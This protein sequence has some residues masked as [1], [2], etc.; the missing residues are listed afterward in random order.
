MSGIDTNIDIDKV[1]LAIAD[2]YHDFL[3]RRCS[4]NGLEP[5][6]DMIKKSIQR[7]TGIEETNIPSSKMF[8]YNGINIKN[9]DFMG[10]DL[11]ETVYNMI[12]LYYGPTCNKSTIDSDILDRILLNDIDVINRFKRFLFNFYECNIEDNDKYYNIGLIYDQFGINILKQLTNQLNDGKNGPQILNIHPICGLW[13]EAGKPKTNRIDVLIGN[14]SQTNVIEHT[15]NISFSFTESKNNV[16]LFN[17][18]NNFT[19]TELCKEIL[20]LGVS[21]LCK[22]YA[23]AVGKKD[24]NIINIILNN[25]RKNASCIMNNSTLYDKI[26]NLFNIELFKNLDHLNIKRSGDYGQISLV[27][28]LNLNNNEIKPYALFKENKRPIENTIDKLNNNIRY[29]LMT[30]DRLCCS[31][32]I[33]EGVPVIFY[34]NK[35]NKLVLYKNILQP[36]SINV[37]TYSNDLHDL[38]IKLFDKLFIERETQDGT[39]TR[40]NVEVREDFEEARIKN[41]PNIVSELSFFRPFLNGIFQNIPQTNYNDNLKKIIKIGTNIDK[42]LLELNNQLFRLINQIGL[43]QLNMISDKMKSR[44]KKLTTML[45]EDYTI[46]MTERFEIIPFLIDISNCEYKGNT[47]IITS[48]SNN[49]ILSF[50]DSII[51]LLSKISLYPSLLH[52]N[53]PNKLFQ[54]IIGAFIDMSIDTQYSKYI[55]LYHDVEDRSEKDMSLLLTAMQNFMKKTNNMILRGYAKNLDGL[56]FFKPIDAYLYVFEK[57]TD[58]FISRIEQFIEAVESKIL[59]IDNINDFLRETAITPSG[60]EV[61]MTISNR[62]TSNASMRT[63]GSTCSLDSTGNRTGGAKKRQN[64]YKGGKCEDKIIM[65]LNILLCNCDNY[66]NSNIVPDEMEDIQIAMN[67]IIYC[68]H[69]PINS[70]IIQS[71]IIEL[72]NI[73][74]ITDKK[75]L[76]NK[77]KSIVFS[78]LRKYILYYHLDICGNESDQ[79]VLKD[80]FDFCLDYRKNSLCSISKLTEEFF[81]NFLYK[82]PNEQTQTGRKSLDEYYNYEHKKNYD[83]FMTNIPEEVDINYIE[84]EIVTMHKYISS[85][86]KDVYTEIQRA[87]AFDP[88]G[89]WSYMLEKFTTAP[90]AFMTSVGQYLIAPLNPPAITSGINLQG[91]CTPST[92]SP[93]KAGPSTEA[94]TTSSGQG[95]TDIRGSPMTKE[96][97]NANFSTIK[98]AVMSTGNIHQESED[99]RL[100]NELWYKIFIDTQNASFEEIKSKFLSLSQQYNYK[101]YDKIIVSNINDIRKIFFENLRI[102]L[103]PSTSSAAMT[104]GSGG[105]IS[106]MKMKLKM[107]D[108]HRKYFTGYYNKY[109]AV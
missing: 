58:I 46:S 17:N 38:I 29:V 64:K 102:N 62:T 36:H 79:Y 3:G 11:E 99:K 23:E 45:S 65:D 86:I 48:D 75:E 105:G 33:I 108:Y 9:T 26:K 88:S 24:K 51:K 10:Y 39:S 68:F 56:N 30:S 97:S 35:D 81:T 94:A 19:H 85:Y 25:N 4:K 70:W 106:K 1:L 12:D 101:E 6:K 2:S 92:S 98:E 82:K 42:S 80:M 8:I 96:T 66:L 107:K 72:I 18:P 44:L 14:N 5:T 20:N 76:I 41:C 87:N 100:F 28:Y 43:L 74:T 103:K 27:K 84:D 16:N 91:M 52:S 93:A 22:C 109:Y 15:N 32:A 89:G 7:S 73:L 60:S 31:R 61:S 49:Y 21:N 69:I 95:T 47:N 90:Q 37:E 55:D 63:I 59:L 50:D 57:Q 71:S 104:S 34:S 40:K 67:Q 77:I 53:N 83:D 54:G 13:D 78:V